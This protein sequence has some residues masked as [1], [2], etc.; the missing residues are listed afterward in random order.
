M[1]LSHQDDNKERFYTTFNLFKL[2]KP[3]QHIKN[4]KTFLSFQGRLSDRLWNAANACGVTVI[5]HYKDKFRDRLGN[6]YKMHKGKTE[7]ILCFLSKFADMKYSEEKTFIFT[8]DDDY[9]VYDSLNALMLFAPWIINKAHKVQQKS[10]FKKLEQLCDGVEF[11]KGGG[12]RIVIPKHL[13]LLIQSGEHEVFSY[14]ELCY[15]LLKMA[16]YKLNHFKFPKDVIFTPDNIPILINKS[17]VKKLE[18]AMEI[19]TRSGGRNGTALSLYLCSKQ[20]QLFEYWL[21]KF[22]F[23]LHGDQGTTLSNWLKLNLGRGYALELSFI[24]NALFG[25]E[26]KKLRIANLITIPHSHMPKSEIANFEMG[27]DLFSVLEHL[28]MSVMYKNRIEIFKSISEADKNNHGFNLVKPLDVK[29]HKQHYF[30]KE[31]LY[32][33]VEKTKISKINEPPLFPS[34]KEMVRRSPLCQYS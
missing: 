18:D 16:N 20:H 5:T 28:R 9:V 2:L 22:S 15:E 34:L 14:K 19:Y 25:R 13:S 10:H 27:L 17:T 26:F 21:S 33:L 30:A 1:I 23:L 11:T 8:L 32:R 7:N 31:N 6:I 12:L 3:F 24:I 4:F 29:G